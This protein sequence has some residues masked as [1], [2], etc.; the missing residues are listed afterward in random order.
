MLA[1]SPKVENTIQYFVYNIN[2]NVLKYICNFVYGQWSYEKSSKLST[3]SFMERSLE[4]NKVHYISWFILSLVYLVYHTYNLVLFSGNRQTF[5]SVSHRILWKIHMYLLVDYFLFLFKLFG[6]YH[7]LVK[8]DLS[9]LMLDLQRHICINTSFHI[10][11]LCL[12]CTGKLFC[13]W[14]NQ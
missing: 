3:S 4:W 8:M 1:K 13:N 12:S 10:M 7:K 9:H 14:S 6:V 5:S 11:C 2:Q